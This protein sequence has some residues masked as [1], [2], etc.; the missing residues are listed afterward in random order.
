MKKSRDKKYESTISH[1]LSK[2][3]SPIRP[4]ALPYYVE[5]VAHAMAEAPSPPPHARTR[6]IC[7]DAE[8]YLDVSAEVDAM[9]LD[10]SSDSEQGWIEVSSDEEILF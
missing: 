10:S 2:I 4:L 6:S 1:H 7:R 8:V 3:R 9:T 5:N